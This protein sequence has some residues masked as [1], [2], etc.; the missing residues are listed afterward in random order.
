M[1]CMGLMA[2]KEGRNGLRVGREV[3]MD[4]AGAQRAMGVKRLGGLAAI[5]VAGLR[6]GL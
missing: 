2:G 6:D 3:V 1:I 5:G 4:V